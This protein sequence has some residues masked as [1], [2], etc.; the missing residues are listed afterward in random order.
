MHWS[1]WLEPGPRALRDW[2]RGFST[3]LEAWSALDRVDWLWSALALAAADRRTLVGSMCEA[4]HATMAQLHPD[5]PYRSASLDKAEAWARVRPLSDRPPLPELPVALR[6]PANLL[7]MAATA[8]P[9][10]AA[11][12]ALDL[13][14]RLATIWPDR[15]GS[16]LTEL[17]D[18][19][20]ELD[21]PFASAPTHR[22]PP[23]AQVAWDRLVEHTRTRAHLT[24]R[25]VLQARS[26]LPDLPSTPRTK[27]G[28]IRERLLL[29]PELTDE[30]E[31]VV[32][33]L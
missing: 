16:A 30:I 24:T 15:R 28:V 14:Q 23:A 20:W 29:A 27:L 9:G 33:T 1:F 17:A 12:V 5:R 22:W 19:I 13:G 21:W 2:A 32:R 31:A 6:Q 7:L 26:L 8:D 11:A 4:V 3:A 25:E 10:A 18:P